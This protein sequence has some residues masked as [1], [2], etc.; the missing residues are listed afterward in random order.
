MNT[1]RPLPLLLASSL[2]LLGL[3]GCALLN[4][5][6]GKDEKQERAQAQA[7]AEAE[8]E[9]EAKRKQEQEDAA[10]AAA[11]DE[12]KAAAEAEDAGP[13]AAV[14]YAVAVKQAVHDGHIERGAVPAAHIAGAEAQLERW[15]AAGAEAD[16]E[17][18]AADLAALELAWGELLVAT[19]RAEE[20]VPHMFAALS[21][22]PTGEHFYAL[23]ALPRSAAADDAVIQAC[24]IRRPEL[25][26]E[27]VPDFMEICLERAGGDASKLRWKKVKKDIAAYEAEL[28]RREAEAA[29]KAEALAKTM[30]QLSAAVFAA[31]DCSFDNCVEEGWKTS[32]DAGTITTNCRFDNCLTDGWDTSFPGG[33][34]AQTRC[35][36]DN[37]MS[38]GWDTSFPG[39][40]TAQTRCRFDNCAE[41]GW[42]TSLP[43]GTTVQTRCNFSKCFEDGW[44]TSLPNGTSVRCDC[45]FDDCLGRGAKCN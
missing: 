37:C 44:T 31:G 45:Q 12:R 33:R 19:D 25:A 29:A 40:R 21:S 42:D 8:A 3:G 36:F 5:L 27:A 9:A 23:V 7:E 38:D 35:R 30:S 16:S 43:D 13:S 26:S 39:G 22:E 17:L 34:T 11:I 15:R 2:P 4:L 28:R 1:P 6:T 32:T 41:D 10:L 24:P 18:A 14:D 20:A